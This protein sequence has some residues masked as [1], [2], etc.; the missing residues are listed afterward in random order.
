MGWRQE[1]ASEF[2]Q[3]VWLFDDT[4]E[5]FEPVTRA[6]PTLLMGFA[7]FLAPGHSAAQDPDLQAQILESQ[8]RL[9]AIRE[10]RARLQA[11]ME[12]I[13]TRVRNASAELNNIESGR[14]RRHWVKIQ[15]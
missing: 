3:A 11:E 7:L 1:Q 5:R 6:L 8:R 15:F 13:R 4:C 12:Q 14:F 2:W 9:E 10:E